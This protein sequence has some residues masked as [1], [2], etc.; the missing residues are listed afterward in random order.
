MLRYL[1]DTAKKSY[2]KLKELNMTPSSSFLDF[3]TF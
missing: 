2:S 1:G 3:T